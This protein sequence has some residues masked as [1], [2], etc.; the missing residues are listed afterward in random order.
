[1][2]LRTDRALKAAGL[3]T[4][5]S[6]AEGQRSWMLWRYV[7]VEDNANDYDKM[8]SRITA[9]ESRHME[10]VGKAREWVLRVRSACSA[11]E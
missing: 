7:R 4:Q 1:M 6:I 11:R 5:G 2:E 10:I 3:Q 8:Q 9:T